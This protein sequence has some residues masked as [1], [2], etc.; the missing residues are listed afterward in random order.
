MMCVSVLTMLQSDSVATVCSSRT[1]HVEI[2]YHVWVVIGTRIQ[3]WRNLNP[4]LF[5][6]TLAEPPEAPN[7]VHPGVLH[8]VIDIPE[9]PTPHLELIG[10]CCLVFALGLRSRVFAVLRLREQL[11][12]RSAWCPG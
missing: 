12:R 4:A 8:V 7:E 9:P 10:A 11:G 1:N 3:G 2:A 6:V 5:P